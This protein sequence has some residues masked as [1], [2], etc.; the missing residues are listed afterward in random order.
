MAVRHRLR[1]CRL[2]HGLTVVEPETTRVYYGGTYLYMQASK[3]AW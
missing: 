1:A 2:I 3:G